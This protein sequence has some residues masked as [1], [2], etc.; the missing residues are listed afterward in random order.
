MKS[1]ARLTLTFDDD[2]RA[3]AVEGAVAP[4]DERSVRTRRRGR[5]VTAVAAADGPMSLL[6]AL[7][8]YLASVSAAER[9][10]REARPRGRTRRRR[11]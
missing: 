10:S 4:D 6:H 2:E 7:D 8:G 1:R 9:T 3:R 11:G 5:T